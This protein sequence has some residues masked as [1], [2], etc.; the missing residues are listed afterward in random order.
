M[1]SGTRPGIILLALAIVL[2]GAPAV[3]SQSACA[4]AWQAGMS[5]TTGQVVSYGGDNWKAIQPEA[6]A[7][8][9]WQPPY[10]PALW[11]S[12]G[13]CTSGGGCT[14]VPSAPTGLTVPSATVTPTSAV[15]DWNAA[16][17]SSSCTVSGYTIFKNGASAGSSSGTSFTATALTPSTKYSFY[18]EAAD[19]A[20]NSAPSAS[21]SVTTPAAAA[22]TTKPSA[23]VLTASGTTSSSTVLSWTIAS[24]PAGCTPLSFTISEDGEALTTVSGQTSF[25]VTG[26]A[27]KTTFTFTVEASDAAGSSPSS[28]SVEVTTSP[29]TTGSGNGHLL[30]GYWHDFLNGSVALPLGQVSSNF[31]VIDVAF[32]G[33]YADTS[34][35]LFSVD[36]GLETQAQFLADVQALHARGKKVVLSIGGENGN[37]ALNNAHDVANFVSSLSGIIQQ[38]GFDGVD[39]DIENN[40]FA[41]EAG[42]NNFTKPITP[43]IVN[44]IGALHQVASR[45]PN[46]I[47]SFAPQITD[48]QEGNIAY[49]SVY[50]DQI[51]L[52]WGCRDILSFVHVQDYNTGGTTA[53]D[54]RS[55]SEG[56]ADFHVAMTEMLLKGFTL[57][58]G[59]VF[60]GFA[61]GQV[62]F[63]VPA[64]SSAGGG[65]TP[66]SALVQ[67]LNYLINGKSFGGEYVLR[68]PSGYPGM[69]GL[70]TWSIDWDE[71]NGFAL[72]DAVAPFLHGL[73]AIPPP[74]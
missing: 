38:Y 47:L 66:P 70:M 8:P 12:L 32:G 24:V 33:T 17:V 7:A 34:T 39:I 59:Q 49:A 45:F 25:T 1:N 42:D 56:T 37:V 46:F 43:T 21:V 67:A 28:N 54:G 11:S 57:A 61:Q 62:A 4:P 72:S 48:V 15:L 10:V 44:M 35:I 58:N 3:F 52:L 69:R 5:V 27:A 9:N 30:V 22:C 60:P 40:S 14:V 55:Y 20:G 29:V 16:T 71:V 65:Y 68:N 18:V 2:F 23:P 36:P 50:G 26:L 13:A 31:D 51:P 74:Q 73:P 63:G 6:S 41:L 53:L 19:A 64:S